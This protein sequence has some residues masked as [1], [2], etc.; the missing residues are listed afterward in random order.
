M[1]GGNLPFTDEGS[2]LLSVVVEG[3]EL[4]ASG[5]PPPDKGRCSVPHP[6]AN[7]AATAATRHHR[8]GAATYPVPRA[9]M[10]GSQAAVV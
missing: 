10:V 6:L 3:A 2:E 4:L 5:P 8:T 1:A 9:P 7:T